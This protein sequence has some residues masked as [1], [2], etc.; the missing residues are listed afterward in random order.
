VRP[1]ANALGIGLGLLGI[2]WLLQEYNFIPG[3][4]LYDLVSWPH[5]G[6]IALA[7]GVVILALSYLNPEKRP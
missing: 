3:Q 7:A 4:F 1:I 2:L 6:A 5:R